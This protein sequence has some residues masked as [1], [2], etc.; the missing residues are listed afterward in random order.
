MKTHL[1]VFFLC[2]LSLCFTTC[3][4]AAVTSGFSAS[5]DTIP[6]D[7]LH[8]IGTGI[9]EVLAE[10]MSAQPSK[11]IQLAP[12]R[13]P[14]EFDT[15]VVDST[16]IV[17]PIEPAPILDP[18]PSCSVGTLGGSFS[19]GRSGA[20]T[21]NLQFEVPHGGSL[22]PQIGLSYNSQ[23]NG[24][25]LAGYG[26]SIT[27][28]SAITRGGYDLFHDGWQ[29]GVTYTAVDN[30]LLDGKRLILQSGTS[31]QDGATYTVEGDPFTK[32]VVHGNYGT[33]EAT[34]WF[35]VTTNT[36][37]TYQ[38]GNSASSKVTYR[39]KSGRARIASWY[40]NKATDKYANY[41]TYEYAISNLSIR[42]IT[43]TYG[44]NSTKSRGIVNRV[45]FIY[46]GLGENAR[47]FTIEDQQGMT[48]MCLSAITTTCNNTI[49]RK[50]TFS[51]A[52]NS[53]YT[54]KKWTRLV[55]I[56]EQ[57]G[58]GKKLSPVHLVWESLPYFNVQ[59]TQLDVPTKDGS[60]IVEETSKMFLSADLNG[61]GVSD[62][63]RIAPVKV[64]T[65]VWPGGGKWKYYTYVYV[66]RSNLSS[67]GNVT[68][69]SP[70]VY[71]LP[72][73]ISFDVIK[74]MFGGASV[75]DFDGDG[76]N[77]LV[78]PFQNAAT[79]LWN[80]VVFY[81]VMGSDVVAGR[82]GG[83]HAFAV[84]LLSTDKAPLFATFDVNGDGKDDVVCVEQRKKDN[85]Y[86]CTI[87]QFAGGTTLNRTDVRLTLPQGIN[88]D[89][90][91]V[92]VSDFNNDGLPDLILLY[93]GGY[94]IYFN[95]GGNNIKSRFMESNTKSG[96]DFGDYWRVQQGDFDGDGLLDFV[97]NK[98]KES[99]LWIARNNGDGTFSSVQTQNI[100][101]ADCF[102]YF[103]DGRFSISVLDVDHDGRSDVVVSKAGY[104]HGSFPA[105]KTKFVDTQVRWLL[106]T[107][108]NLRL[109]NSYVTNREDDATENF[110]L[111]G[112]FDGDGYAE[113]A[114]YGGLL[115]HGGNTPRQT[116]QFYKSGHDLTQVGKIT[117]IVDSMGN[118]S[119][120]QYANAT[121]PAVYGKNIKSSYPVNTYTLPL[122]VV[123]K[124]T[125]DNG[126]V[127]SQVNKYFYEDLRLHVA[128]RGM[129]GFNTVTKE[130]TTLG[131]KE[132]SS[133]TQWD[134]RVWIPTEVKTT[135]SIG[136]N[137]STD[138]TTYSVSTTGK[139]YF[140]YV[141]KKNMTDLDGNM[142]TTISNYDVSKGVLTDETV[143]NDGNN[144]Y[145]KVSY[146]GYQ[147]KAGVWL[148]TTLTMSQKHADDPTPYT[149]VT[150]YGYDDRGN[151]LYA[152]VNS[153]TSMALKTTSTYDV[154]GN[155]L[156]SVTTGN[157]VKPISKFNDYD[158]SGRFVIKSFTN[159]AS[160]VNTFIYDLWG[161][162][163]AESDATEPSNIMT[164]RYTYDG[165]GRRLTADQADGIQTTYETGWGPADNKRYYTMES[166]T[167]KPSVTMW[168][169]KGGYEVLQESFGT[170]GMP[171]SKATIYNDKGQVSRV[172]NKTG[173][174]TITQNLTYDE[175]GRVVTDV[176]S[177]GKSV[178]YSYGNRSVTTTIAGRSYTKTT[179]AWGNVV[180]ST[181][182]VSEVE[183]QYSSIGKPSSVKTQGSTVSMT[184]D[185][186]GN[187]LS[188]SD[189]DA[190]T[191]NYTYA[192]DGTLLTQTD[193]RGIKTINSYDNLGRLA[194]T[195]IGQKHIS[196]TYGITG[197][198]KLRLVKQ[199]VDNNSVEY[200]HDK[201]GRVIS[202]KRT[203]DGHGSY[204]FSYSYN[205]NNQLAKTTYPGGLEV[206]YLYDDYGFKAQSAIGDKVIY[207]VESADGLV[208]STSFMG[209]L[210]AMQT[211]DSRGYESNVKIMR[212]TSVLE[213]FDETYDGATDNLL[214]RRR[215]NNPQ[216]T[217]G[218]DNLDRLVSVKS[219]ATE[220]MRIN[221]APNGNI[222]FKTGVGNFSY[223]E[224]VRPHAVT[225]VE[226]ADGQIPGDALNTSFNDFGKVELIEDAGKNLR[227]DFA[228]GPDQDRWYSELS[229]NGTDVRTTVYAGE[230]EKITENGVTREFY[231]LDGNTIVIRENGTV[232]TYLAFTDNLGSILSV[233]DENGTKVF[234]ASYDAWGKQTVTLN[235]IG[236]HRGYTGHEMLNEFDIIN[237]NGRL[238][239]PV[240]GR[241]FS[242]DNYVQMPDNSQNFNR[243]S[244]CLNNP[245]K[246]TD[247]SGNLFGVDDAIIA[248]AAF[249]MAS[250][251]MLAAFEGKSV[252]KAGALSL[253]S[254]A[255][256]YG[257]GAAFG[258]VSGL[259]NEL[260]RAGAHGLASGLVSALDGGNF[261]SAFVSGAAASGIG[262]FAQGVNMNPALMIAST[263]VMGGLA[264]WATGG[265]FLQGAMQGMTIGLFNHAAHNDGNVIGGNSICERLPDGTYVA[266]ADLKEVIVYGHRKLAYTPKHPIEKPL[267]EIHPEFDILML[268]RAFF[269]G[270]IQAIRAEGKSVSDYIKSETGGVNS[271]VRTH[272][273][274]SYRGGFDTR[275][276]TW[277]S[278]NYYRQKIGNSYLR[279]LNGKLRNSRI[280]I[281]S[282][283]TADKGHFHWK[284]G[285]RDTDEWHWFRR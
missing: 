150:T 210:T 178:S 202:E 186:A 108:S 73:G 227:M 43:I 160:A 156:S 32:V 59:S 142:V 18:D 176:L 284:W 54:N 204:S 44:T 275:S 285:F 72:S 191:S 8:G 214:S 143:M 206:S 105:Y 69:D 120:I 250:S 146:S 282:W 11:H 139:N 79:G 103:D 169:D 159:P 19:V 125:S 21:Y 257:I 203:V 280:P 101:V 215:N 265:D 47:P 198:E 164:T 183:Y 225:E 170:K 81:L 256:S 112:D 149:T 229:K 213:S 144:M 83:I 274:Y 25:G 234:D 253:L 272:D 20:A 121:S 132:T 60:S 98:S 221:Y 74:S 10:N 37:M 95:N 15:M 91:K 35:E 90:G 157:G 107:G 228:Y 219:G 226:N 33:S 230:Y 55:R 49:Y 181:D 174:L 281:N 197:N 266:S 273:S 61:D 278:N 187:Q 244:Y 78:F 158:L 155:V 130:N 137:T 184:Y 58:E 46:R 122:S 200:T 28:I 126:S 189:P 147:N 94:K 1:K 4:Q 42:P 209:K 235:S 251:M 217:F 2:L 109:V 195:Q 14:A 50:Y 123:E 16:R 153:G 128:G 255:A 39:N 154:Y 261:A 166:T 205:G 238:Y 196:Y 216:E 30:L 56:E 211:R 180:K 172:E 252:W 177:S 80:Q 48:D 168:Y 64:T 194:S 263:T 242:P 148:P 104:K 26:F 262:S 51:Y 246:Y 182:P 77:D 29:G 41:I 140:A 268:G 38:Y 86:P 245:L 117:R 3:I 65:A 271:W 22:T 179:D 127:C 71:T 62:I 17:E 63:I 70:M 223:D 88:K 267:R 76:Y 248:L 218:Y 13:R 106:S 96:T 185:A 247:P 212:G 243:Y 258:G 222:L 145:K 161:N 53:D 175:R 113:L 124:V 237:M 236:L 110:I 276:T 136:N 207:K 23:L 89:I 5:R 193:G 260:L 208:S 254:S 269:Q 151:V 131:T 259:G 119:Y 111:I 167:G 7:S 27:G 75:M 57:N 163:L 224:H 24:Y 84:N 102:S 239:D 134:E 264:A 162:V 240:L 220:T 9:N 45:N 36:G 173:K 93:D 270:A 279:K 129:L 12:G 241:F 31:G 66:S 52:D 199:A 233:M 67:T 135:T 6:R 82:A 141:T 34:T 99:C 188:L 232:K 40:V 97:Y 190:G 114:N 100:G 152:T 277:G 165:W 116:F 138:V 115:N 231:Y 85:Y 92:F 283:R 171:V 133:V 249:N 192:A 118:D 68:Y 201:F 87:V